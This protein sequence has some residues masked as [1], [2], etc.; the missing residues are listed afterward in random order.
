MS[1]ILWEPDL[2]SI[3][4][5]RMFHFL[6]AVNKEFSLSLKTYSQL[7]EWSIRHYQDFWKF[8]SNYS[9]IV[10]KVESLPIVLGLICFFLI[11]GKEFGAGSNYCYFGFIH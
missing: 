5:S 10:F 7:H 9:H 4:Q 8:Y 6:E 1:A 2:Q 11:Q 3:K